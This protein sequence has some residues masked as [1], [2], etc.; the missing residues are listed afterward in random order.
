MFPWVAWCCGGRLSRDRVKTI[1]IVDSLRGCEY[2]RTDV[3]RVRGLGF[4]AASRR[5]VLECSQ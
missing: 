1:V 2:A 5:M 4:V 3:V